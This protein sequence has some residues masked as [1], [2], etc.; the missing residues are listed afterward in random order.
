[1]KEVVTTKYAIPAELEGFFAHPP[2]LINE[3]RAHYNQ[4]LTSTIE[5][6][7]PENTLE[8]ILVKD[9]VDLTWEDRRLGKMK[10][11]IVNSTWKDAVRTILE[12]L[13]HGDLEERRTAA[14]ELSG[15]YFSKEGRDRV[16]TILARHKL[17]EDAIA[18]H[19]LTLRLPELEL[20][21]RQ[22]QR[23]RLARIAIARDLLH[24]RVAGAWKRPNDVLAIVD[25]RASSIPLVPSDQTAPAS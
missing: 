7:E 13:L 15:A 9:L 8:W 22:V 25:A 16:L 18:A 6:I 5:T 24:H 17:T 23:V 4:V 1:M 20:I 11:D 19:S 2:I 12:S 3:F 10:A 21:D 14:R